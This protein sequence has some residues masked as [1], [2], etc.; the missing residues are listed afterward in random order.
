ML[1]F[2]TPQN[3]RIA[4]SPTGNAHIGL[5]RT[6]YLNYLAART[7]GGKFILR[8]DD[9]DQLRSR[10]EYEDNILRTFEWLGLEWDELHYQSK[11]LPRHQEVVLTY[12]QRG[13]VGED[14]E[15]PVALKPSRFQSEW[16]DLIAGKMAINEEQQKV[17][18]GL[19]LMRQGWTPTYHLASVIDD[20]DLGINL[21]IR[22]TDHISNTAKHVH[23]YQE[24]VPEAGLP[25]FA[26]V[27]LI[28]KDGRKISKR[29]DAA[30]MEFYKQNN[31][32]PEAILNAVLKLGWGHP[33]PQFDKKYPIIDKQMA[34]ELF[35]E[36]HLKSV[37]STLDM[38]KLEW[39]NKKHQ[40][41]VA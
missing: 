29:E 12:L 7:S 25:T 23:I 13:G 24:L 18:D 35:P 37:K 22:G 31:Y 8:I 38:N 34:M 41:I 30:N 2:N 40:Q 33:D 16:N 3:T 14:G 32:H 6:A 28:F 27:G 17:I 5:V 4:P 36:G 39:L 15:G 26:H 1:K 11:R 19:I 9:T 21:V 10:K 20:A